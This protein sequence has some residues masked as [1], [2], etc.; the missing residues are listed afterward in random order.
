MKAIKIKYNRQMMN[1]FLLLILT[2]SVACSA[3]S[4]VDQPNNPELKETTINFGTKTI[5]TTKYTKKGVPVVPMWNYKM[6]TK[7][8]LN[9]AGFE[10]LSKG[11]HDIVW[12]PSTREE[13]AFNHFV[14]M[15]D[16][17]DK[18][19]I[20][21]GNHPYGEDGPGQRI[22]MSSSEGWGKWSEPKVLFDPPCPVE[23]ESA[24]DNG[25]HLTPDRWSIIRG[26][27]YAIVYNF[28][29]GEWNYLL[30]R[31]VYSDGSLGVPF[32]LRTIP[33][34]A[35]LPDFMKDLPNAGFVT[36]LAN[37]LNEWYKQ[38]DQISWWA[39]ANDG[40]QRPGV[41]G[42]NL[43]ES[44]TYRASDNRQVLLLRSH[45]WPQ[46]PTH[47]NRLYVSF[48]DGVGG[49][50]TPYPTDIPDA[51]SRTEAV[52]GEDGT[53]YLIGNQIA[54][55]FDKPIYL[56]RDPI[57]IS[58]SKDGYVFDKAYALRVGAPKTYRFDGIT[59]RN[60]GFAYS[61][62]FIKNGWLYISYSLNKEEIGISRVKLSELKS[63]NR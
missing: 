11:E 55:E 15:I 21:W 40:V 23:P 51:P 59:R 52:K 35:E 42:E 12:Q 3:D 54:Y 49:W 38:S 25:P 29:T 57:T 41:D 34:K 28:V 30:A 53:V 62:S 26:K 32:I 1:I 20:M 8:Y 58:V 19:Y 14:A 36:P 9:G 37:E 63:N 13:G 6:P 5:V 10:I 4:K 33:S 27:L 46:Q 44:F 56:D 39:N 17:Q 7:D 24:T 48:N 61:S 2:I 18:F 16:Y 22:L 45:G 47:N 31:E 60:P 50:P 43:I